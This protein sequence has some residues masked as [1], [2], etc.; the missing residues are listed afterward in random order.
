MAEIHAGRF[1]LILH[2]FSG[3]SSG[4]PATPI[5]A[6][7]GERVKMA[8]PGF[9]NPCLSSGSDDENDPQSNGKK[10]S[11]AP[12]KKTRTNKDAIKNP[13]DILS[14]QDDTK[15]DKSD[16]DEVIK[17]TKSRSKRFVSDDVEKEAEDEA[18]EDDVIEDS[19]EPKS[20]PKRKRAAKKS[21]KEKTKKKRKSESDDDEFDPGSDGS[22]DGSGSDEFSDENISDS[23]FMP[24]ED[25]EDGEDGA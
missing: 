12:I 20:P 24:G 22:S 16:D 2:S 18:M 4:F 10:K 25:G 8:R 17:P 13:A 14:D 9:W 1:D 15:S 7:V 3:D 21:K 23:D 11:K 19:P 5:L 6:R